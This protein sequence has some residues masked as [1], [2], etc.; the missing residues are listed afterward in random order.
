MIVSM[1]VVVPGTAVTRLW[2]RGLRRIGLQLQRR[3]VRHA[4][5]ARFADTDYGC[6]GFTH[7]M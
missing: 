5:D 1:I 6:L 7:C 4:A 3:T 2:R